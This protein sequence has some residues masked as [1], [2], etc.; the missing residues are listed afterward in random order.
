[1]LVEGVRVL[2]E[3]VAV[4]AL[5]DQVGRQVDVLDVA[6][7]AVLVDPLLTVDTL[8]VST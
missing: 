4:L 3:A 1:M 5:E 7:H 6:G 8:R 2:K